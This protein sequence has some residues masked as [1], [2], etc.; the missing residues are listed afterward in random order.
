MTLQQAIARQEG[1]GK[2]GTRATMNNNPG[3]IIWGEFAKSHGSAGGDDAGYAV[4]P[5][6]DAGFAALTDLLTDP[7]YDHDT[8]EQAINT[9]LGHPSANPL[10][11]GNDA[12]VYIQNV[13][14]WCDCL[15]TTPI[16]DLLT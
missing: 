7:T 15:P 4:F 11:K 3:N 5:S 14:E 12:P 6:Q 8:V 13:C 10:S 2:P 9:Y 1:F 16:V